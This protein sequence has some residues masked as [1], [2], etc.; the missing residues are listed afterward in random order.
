M[1]AAEL[2]ELSRGLVA[3]HLA[4]GARGAADADGDA[5]AAGDEGE[6]DIDAGLAHRARARHAIELSVQRLEG[7]VGIDAEIVSELAA[8]LAAAGERGDGA[9]A[10]GIG[11]RHRGID[12]VEPAAHALPGF[13]D[14]LA[15]RGD[16]VL[17]GLDRLQR[18]APGRRDHGLGGI[19]V[20]QL[21]RGGRFT[22]AHAQE[23]GTLHS[24]GAP[25]GLHLIAVEEALHRH[26][27]D[28]LVIGALQEVRRQHLCRGE[29]R[30]A[31]ITLSEDGIGEKGQRR[32][33]ASAKTRQRFAH[34]PLTSEPF[35]PAA[36]A[37]PT[38]PRPRRD[39]IRESPPGDAQSNAHA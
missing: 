22:H 34:T 9:F 4:Y 18:G 24:E 35:Q 2:L 27:A 37:A 19:D 1:R 32:H 21:R 20:L 16:E 13:A 15:W 29:R 39:Y 7:G 6:A 11:R 31:L 38:V 3:Q 28:D 33:E 25:L 26:R 36:G 8:R 5:G 10:I 17:S 23:L 12:A 14:R 30:R